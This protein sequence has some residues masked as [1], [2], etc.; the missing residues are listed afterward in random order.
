MKVDTVIR[1]C[2]IVRFDKTIEAGIAVQDG[3]FVMIAE[4]RLLP[5]GAR[6][7]DAGKKYVIPGIID[8]HVH[9]DWPDWDFA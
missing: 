3:K 1:N 6:V 4:D 2:R 5:E 7:I 9:V 8:P